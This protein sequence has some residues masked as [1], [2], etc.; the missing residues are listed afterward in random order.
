MLH[1][2]RESETNAQYHADPAFVSCSG[3]KEFLKAPIKYPAYLRKKTNNL[4]EDFNLGT[5]AHCA[6]LERDRFFKEYATAPDLKDYPGALKTVDDLK[7]RLSTLGLKVSGKKEEL[8]SRLKES[9]PTAIFWDDIVQQKTGG[10][11]LVTD[12][13]WKNIQ[14]MVNSLDRD[15]DASA[16]LKKGKQELS[17]RFIDEETGVKMKARFD[18]FLPETGFIGDLKTFN[19]VE[20]RNVQRHIVKMQYHLQSAWYCRAASEIMGKK[21]TEMVHFFIETED[22]W[23]VVNYCL[24]DASIERADLDISD[25]LKRFSACSTEQ[26]WPG[27]LPGIRSIALPDYCFQYSGGS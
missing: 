11:R 22:P 26:I 2:I 3:F 5:A 14:G 9:D 24:D 21:V 6:F 17:V 18:A 10:K 1:D 15:P 20:E 4:D 8:T 7:D 25:G 23:I 19:S 27:P 16:F 13:H 12:A